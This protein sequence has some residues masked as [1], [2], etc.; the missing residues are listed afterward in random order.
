MTR[1]LTSLF[2]SL[3]ARQRFQHKHRVCDVFQRAHERA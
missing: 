2:Q 1:E 3:L